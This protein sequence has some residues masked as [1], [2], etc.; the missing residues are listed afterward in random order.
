MEQSISFISWYI[1]VQDIWIW[2]LQLHTKAITSTT[3]MATAFHSFHFIHSPF[4]FRSTRTTFCRNVLM[5]SG[6]LFVEI[7]SRIS[8]DKLPMPSSVD[9]CTFHLPSTNVLQTIN[10]INIRQYCTVIYVSTSSVYYNSTATLEVT[11]SRWQNH[12]HCHSY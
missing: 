7:W 11:E 10:Y 4:W 3:S 12:T 2:R 8:F 6:S 9:S 5:S 1:S